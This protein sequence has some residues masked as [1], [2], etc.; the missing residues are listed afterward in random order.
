MNAL[1]RVVV[2]FLVVKLTN[3]TVNLF[4]FPVLA[5][6]VTPAGDAARVSLLIPV[7]D[8]AHRLPWTLAGLLAQDVDEILLLD[9]GSTDGSERLL[10]RE[11]RFHSTARVVT[12]RPRPTGWTGKTWALS[13]LADQAAGDVLVFC[14]ADVELAPGAIRAV[15]AEMR[16]QKADAFSVFPRQRTG[17]FGEHLLVPLIDD[18]LLCYL[19]FPLLQAPVPSA[20]TANGSIFAFERT[21]LKALGGFGTVRTHV[22]EDV[23]M[24][25]RVRRQGF[26]LGLALGGDLVQARMY[27]SWS[28]VVTGFGRGLRPAVGGSRA[29]LVLG[30]VWHLAVYTFPAVRA[31]QGAR[32][33]QVPLVLAMLE[34]LLVEAKTGR[35]SWFQA[36]LVPLGPIAATPVVGR[37]MRRHQTWKGRVYS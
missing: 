28:G 4:R 37:A 14:D 13:Q 7:R 25:R 16:R 11:T 1:Y 8:E 3:L 30:L 35:R 23:A 26:G 29:V 12:G 18:V 33:W 19:P 20:A 36:L 17:S 31:V 10:L 6:A 21:C 2:A 9:D 27:E 15:L 5:P 24:A 22:V 34:R 32:R